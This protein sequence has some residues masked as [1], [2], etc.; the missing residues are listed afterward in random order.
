MLLQRNLFHL[1]QGKFTSSYN[2]PWKKLSD[3]RE[4]WRTSNSTHEKDNIW[5]TQSTHYSH[6]TLKSKN[7]K[8]PN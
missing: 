5:M 2:V 1:K 8:I 4:V 7:K 3:D 6:L